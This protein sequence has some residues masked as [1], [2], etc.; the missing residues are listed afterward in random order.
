VITDT[1]AQPARSERAPDIGVETRD[2]IEF[3]ESADLDPF[4]LWHGPNQDVGAFVVREFHRSPA[5]FEVTT[6]F[7]ARDR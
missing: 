4:H 7:H 1:G 2:N 6:R 3:T 5:Q